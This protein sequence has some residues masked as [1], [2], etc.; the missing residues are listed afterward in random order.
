[1]KIHTSLQKL[2]NENEK[3]DDDTDDAVEAAAT[4]DDDDDAD[5]QHDPYVPAMLRRRHKN[6]ITYTSISAPLTKSS[7]DLPNEPLSDRYFTT[8]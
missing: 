5:G 6:N 7:V 2:F 1:M 4:A 3:C 8:K